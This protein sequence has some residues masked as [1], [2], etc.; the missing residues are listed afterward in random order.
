MID[1]TTDLKKY[2]QECNWHAIKI[3]VFNNH[4]IAFP[5]WQLIGLTLLLWKTDL[6]VRNHW[7]DLMGAGA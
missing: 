6:F 1:L 2:S 4:F 5:N 3:P 7:M